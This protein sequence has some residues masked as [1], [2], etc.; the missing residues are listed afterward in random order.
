MVRDVR[1]SVPEMMDQISSNVQDKYILNA[2]GKPMNGGQLLRKYLLIRCQEDFERGWANKET[3]TMP[4][5]LYS[6]EYYALQ[7]AKR[8]GL[9]LDR[10]IVELYKLGMLTERIMH[11]C[12]QML[13]K[14]VDEPREEGLE[15]LCVLLI[16]AGKLLDTPRA[17][18]HMD[19]YF[20]RMKAFMGKPTT[21][22]RLQFMIEVR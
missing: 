20:T 21:S 17:R 18:G 13:L 16:N 11:Q 15:N 6:D 4:V 14:N 7:K 2:K 9:G 1:T 8:Q 5:A 3:S 22:L 10:F 19:V 12:V